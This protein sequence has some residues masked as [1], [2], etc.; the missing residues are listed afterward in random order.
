[1]PRSNMTFAAEILQRG[2]IVLINGVRNLCFRVLILKE[3][4]YKHHQPSKNPFQ[5][6]P[7]L[8]L[9]S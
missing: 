6:L 1:M 4:K 3:L 9:S 7:A 2:G 8:I 5:F